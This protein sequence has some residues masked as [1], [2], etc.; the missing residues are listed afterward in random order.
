MLTGLLALTFLASVPAMALGLVKP[1]LVL[2]WMKNATRKRVILAYGGTFVASF[3]LIGITTPSGTTPQ[4]T[5]LESRPPISNESAIPLVTSNPSPSVPTETPSL[6]KVGDIV[7]A[8]ERS[9]QVNIVE[10]HQGL[11]AENPFTDPIDGDIILVYATFTNTS[12]N[13]GISCG[14]VLI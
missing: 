12:N 14:A 1:K 8:N 9:I 10:K 4:E 6:P 2:P 11:Q 13:Q 3:V 7:S 5:S